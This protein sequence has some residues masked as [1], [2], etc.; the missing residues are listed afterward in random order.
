M[1]KNRRGLSEV[2]KVSEIKRRWGEKFREGERVNEWK[3]KRG[4]GF[5]KHVPSS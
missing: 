3:D 4:S 1:R 2:I 5:V